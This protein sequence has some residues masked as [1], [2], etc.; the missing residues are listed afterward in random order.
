M[1]ACGASQLP[2]SCDDCL[3]V[4]KTTKQ[5]KIPCKYYTQK[6]YTVKVP[7]QVTEKVPRNVNYVDY[8]TRQ[9]QVP[10]TVNR[11]ERRTRMETQKYQVPVKRCYTVMETREKQVAVPYF[12]NV[13]ETKYRTESYQVPVQRSKVQ[14]DTV[15]KTIYDTK[16][17]RRC[18]PQTRIC[19]KEI[20]VYNVVA[21]PCGD[22]SANDVV[23]DFNAMDINGDGKLS[24]EEMFGTSVKNGSQS[25]ENAAATVTPV[26]A[27]SGVVNGSAVDDMNGNFVVADNEI[28]YEAADV[29]GYQGYYDP[30]GTL[31]L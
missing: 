28:P 14:M 31:V 26:D 2:P 12:V 9:K 25:A 3:E 8:E 17:Q 15:T 5:V 22:C 20:P 30:R 11:S 24:Y 7:R 16:V 23:D 29:N 1:S 27:V 18:I 21:K 19:A 10:Y 4:V 6:M 13:P